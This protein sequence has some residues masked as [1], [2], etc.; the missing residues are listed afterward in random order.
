M[1]EAFVPQERVGAFVF[2]SQGSGKEGKSW[3][4]PDGSPR[5]AEE[6]GGA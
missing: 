2:K 5:W 4:V 3:V 1:P 6:G